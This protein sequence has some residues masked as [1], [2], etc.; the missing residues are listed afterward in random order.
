MVFTKMSELVI[1]EPNTN[2]TMLKLLT[3][4]K[5]SIKL[6]AVPLLNGN[7]VF[8]EDFIDGKFERREKRKKLSALVSSCDEFI[9]ILCKICEKKKPELIIIE[10][11]NAEWFNTAVNILKELLGKDR[12]TVVSFRERVDSLKADLVIT[13][14]GIL[15]N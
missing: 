9:E 7:F 3:R 1:V 11:A 14:N 13:P 5:K 6:N 4:G 10:K 8:V 12:V 2:N 15:W